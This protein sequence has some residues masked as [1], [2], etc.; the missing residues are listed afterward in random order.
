MSSVSTHSGEMSQESQSASAHH[1]PVT[2]ARTRTRPSSAAE[3]QRGPIDRAGQASKKMMQTM[4]LSSVGLEFGFSVIIGALFGRWLDSEAGTDP[5]LMILFICLGF[6][7]GVRALYRAMKQ[8][9]REAA[10]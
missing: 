9:D 4:S 7:A 6:A 5:W 3:G 8:A 10:S 2:I 1:T